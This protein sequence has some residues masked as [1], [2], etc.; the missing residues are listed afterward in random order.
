MTHICTHAHAQHKCA[1]T[2]HTHTHNRNY[3]T[4][5][6]IMWNI[7]HIKKIWPMPKQE[8]RKLKALKLQQLHVSY[9]WS[10]YSSNIYVTCNICF[11]TNLCLPLYT[12]SYGSNID[13]IPNIHLKLSKYILKRAS[14]TPCL[15][16]LISPLYIWRNFHFA[17]CKSLATSSWEGLSWL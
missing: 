17:P 11:S 2:A 12:K 6:S 8:N 3:K 16:K 1:H 7:I 15:V 14:F 9:W 4:Q 10:K 13:V 5:K